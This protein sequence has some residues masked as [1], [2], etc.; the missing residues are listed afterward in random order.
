MQSED[1]ALALAIQ[2]SLNDT[3][4]GQT[5]SK[6]ASH[7]NKPQTAQEQEDLALAQA[8]AQS[9]REEENRRRVGT[10]SLILIFILSLRNLEKTKINFFEKILRV[11]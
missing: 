10:C 3:G 4:S 6:P 11:Q 8:L 7:T 9:E 5:I 2:A 1:E